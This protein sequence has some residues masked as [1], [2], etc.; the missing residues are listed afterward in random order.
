MTKIDETILKRYA[1]V[2]IKFALNDYKGINKGDKVYVRIPE[3][4]REFLPY[5]QKSILES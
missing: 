4:A 5:L 2:I 1:D 3:A